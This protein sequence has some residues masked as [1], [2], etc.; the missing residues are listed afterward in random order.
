MLGRLEKLCVWL[1]ARRGAGAVLAAGAAAAVAYNAFAATSTR[2]RVAST[3][4]R[5]RIPIV[6]LF[7]RLRPLVAHG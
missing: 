2:L 3:K 4:L 7:L 5:E 6:L 1:L